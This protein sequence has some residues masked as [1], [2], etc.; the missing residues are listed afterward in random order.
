MKHNLNSVVPY[1]T[2]RHGVA[3]WQP[4][5][6]EPVCFKP[7]QPY[8]RVPYITRVGYPNPSSGGVIV[9]NQEKGT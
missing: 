6:K 9:F 7:V 8:L 1:S 3:A 4:S 2:A 5:S